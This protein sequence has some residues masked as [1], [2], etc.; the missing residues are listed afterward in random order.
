[1]SELEIL[2]PIPIDIVEKVGDSYMEYSMSVIVGR[3]LP[4]VR[5][6]LKP[7]HRRVL[8]AM[9]EMGLDHTKRHRKSAL[10]VGEVMGKYHPH[11][12]SAIYDTLVRMAQ[13]FSLRYPLVDGQGNFGSVDGDMPAAMRYT[14][15]R[16][17]K[18][19]A[20]LLADIDK[21]TVDFTPNYESSLEEPVVLPARIPNLLINGSSGIAVGMATNIPPHN[22]TEIMDAL[23]L[24]IDNPSET[25]SDILGIVKGPD[26]PTGAIIMGR[27][28]IA[29]AYKTG[30]GSVKIR[31]KVE[32]EPLKN[33]REQ[34]IVT[35][36]PYQVNKAALIEKIAELVQEKKITGISDLW[37]LSDSKIRIVIELKRGEVA[38]VILNQLY[39][40]TP[41]ETSFGINMVV[42]IGG[43]PKLATLTEI[44]DEFLA[45]RIV[46][47]TR[48]TSYMLKKA[49]ERLHIIEGLRVAVENIDEVV[50]AIKNSADS[51]QA[52]EKLRERYKLSETQAQAIMEMRL[53]RLTGL[54][55]N[56]LN[57]EYET[58]LKD[59]ER[60]NFI[61]AN[62]AALMGVIRGEFEEIKKGYGDSRLTE[63]TDEAGEFE[64]L[65]LIP[66]DDMAVTI[67]HAG[68]IKRTPLSNFTAQK[69]GGKGKSGAASRV[70]DFIEQL[71]VT[72]NHSQ[73]LFFTKSGRLHFLDVYKLPEMNRDTKGRHI[74]NFISV[75]GEDKVA[76]ILTVAGKDDNRSVILATRKGEI[77]RIGITEFRSGRSGMFVIKLDDGDEL[78]ASLLTDENDKIF[79]ASK[80]AKSIQFLA[81]DIRQSKRGSGGVRGMRL[82]ADDA[83]V[84]VAVITDQGDIMT[85]TANGYGKRTL[86]S[87][88][89]EQSRGGSGL[90]LC[91]V[92]PKTGAVVS[93]IQVQPTDD[94]MMIT[95]NGKTIRFTVSGISVIGRG[96]QG[97]KLMETDG[98]EII[99]AAVVRDDG[100]VSEECNTAEV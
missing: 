36:I 56:K 28:E 48:R 5:D 22:L 27:S 16:M 53:S 80:Q 88:Y 51:Q 90:K 78:V 64:T 63:I 100:G 31:S 37:D 71:L 12:D 40:F 96:T 59:I 45:H 81:K 7:V 57:T 67:T 77:K 3:A 20:E 91:K 95:K 13:T 66:N 42:L 11:G 6:G 29:K 30:R 23:I 60:F 58:L 46:V 97:V 83:V 8:F 17:Q 4:D 61:L 99:S 79:M 35:E 18:I 52:K 24:K 10:V 15:S 50:A 39:K 43:R 89:R 76:S 9:H 49:E 34:I 70:D 47:V 32:V 93:A 86:I 92:T 82:G 75:E 41:L 21:N 65:D 87:E 69:R 38:E 55:I 19:A 73:L 2:K 44:L 62:R 72:A 94:I 33:G 68:Y 98:D 26:F 25:E 54:E 1:M 85:V 74:S 14:E 84:S